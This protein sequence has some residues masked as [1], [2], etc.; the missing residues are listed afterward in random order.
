M[1]LSRCQVAF[2]DSDGVEHSI[3]VDAESLYEAVAVAI[4]EFRAAE[5]N[6]DV[7]GPMTEFR[8]T[9]F[10]KPIEHRIRLKR[11]MKW[12]E[13]NT[14]EGPAGITKR[15]RVRTLLGAKTP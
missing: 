13:P 11:V 1:A 2:I 9:V 3:E 14:K 7:P 10:R 4:A 15:E 8:A 12:A 6:I 5:I